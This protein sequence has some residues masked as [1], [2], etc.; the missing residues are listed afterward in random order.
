MNFNFELLLTIA[1]LVTGIIYLVDI[2]YWAPQRKQ[3]AI[4]KP[5]HWI[6][7]SRSF[8]PIL[9]IVLLL[10]SFLAEPF[11]IPSGSEK[12]ALLVGD[13]IVTSKFAYGVRLPVLHTKVLSVGEPA[14]GDLAVFRTPTDNSTYFIK[15][16]IG[17]PG[18]RISYI[19]KV[20]Y[21]NGVVANQK[22]LGQAID[23]DEEGHD[24]PVE[25]K[26]EDLLGLK[27]NV[28]VRADVPVQD[29]SVIVPPGEYFAMGDNRD[30]SND[31]R[32]WGFVPEQNLVG[33]ALWIWFSWDGEHHKVLWHRM[34]SRIF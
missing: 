2:C 7:Y 9:I 24:W 13:F 29:F 1:T 11:R 28:Y 5:P 22:L 17:L 23:T 20:L 4:E 14:R 27:H 34:G 21:I 19:N 6:E 31:S 26:E 15:R 18:D 10:R 30:N 32:Y 3:L 16:I 25:L 12:P 8:F 33:K